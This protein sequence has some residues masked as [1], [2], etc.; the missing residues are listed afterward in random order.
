MCFLID[1]TDTKAS[2][3]QLYDCA[4][5]SVFF[6]LFVL[7]SARTHIKPQ[8]CQNTHPCVLYAAPTTISSYSQRLDDCTVAYHLH[9]Q[10]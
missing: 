9:C 5:E 4:S 2:V 10:I 6:F 8:K 7:L 3:P 1:F